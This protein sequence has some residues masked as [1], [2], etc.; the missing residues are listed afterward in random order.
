MNLF[1][2]ICNIRLLFLL[3][4]VQGI[5]GCSD[6]EILSRKEQGEEPTVETQLRAVIEGETP[7]S[8]TS[9]GE[10]ANNV[11]PTLWSE[12]DVIRVYN[13]NGSRSADFTLVEGIGTRNAV[14]RGGMPVNATPGYSAYPASTATF[15]AGTL[16]GASVPETQKYV[17]ASVAPNVMPMAG[18]STNYMDFKYYNLCGILRLNIGG[19]GK[20][21][22]LYLMG[23]NGEILSGKVAIQ[24]SSDGSPAAA[25]PAEAGYTEYHLVKGT[26]GSPAISID[27]GETPIDVSKE[28]TVTVNIAVMPQTFKNGITVYITDAENNGKFVKSSKSI[29]LK[30]GTVLTMKTFD[31]KKPKTLETANCYVVEEGGPYIIP[32]FCRGNKSSSKLDVSRDGF[33]KDRHKVAADY[34]WTDAPDAITNITYLP[35]DFGS[36]VFNVVPQTPKGNTVI[37]LY[38]TETGEIIW[39][40]HIWM[41]KF[42]EIHT[43]GRCSA[44]VEGQGNIVTEGEAANGDMVIMD[45]NLGAVSADPENGVES[46]GLYYQYG[47]KDPFVGASKVGGGGGYEEPSPS[48]K[49]DIKKWNY[50]EKVAFDT[51]AS[52]YTSTTMVNP[53]FA[54]R[55]HKWEYERKMTSAIGSAKF[56]MRF[57]ASN[58]NL[59]LWTNAKQNQGA[60]DPIVVDDNNTDHEILWNR[61][62][63]IY[64]PCPAGWTVIGFDGKNAKFYTDEAVKS[65]EVV[66]GPL[67]YGIWISPKVNGI[68]Q[69][70]QWW[71]SSGFRDIKGRVADLG[72][73]SVSWTC[74]HV[75]HV[76][77][78]HSWTTTRSIDSRNNVTYSSNIDV[79]TPNAGTVRCVRGLQPPPKK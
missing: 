42:N 68:A 13:S 1:K 23:N 5:V 16:V 29:D 67:S 10:L 7:A 28:N 66:N 54:E 53:F 34:L 15:S 72:E 48:D 36:I 22:G 59:Y 8:R 46:Y 49:P 47:R 12:N 58:D 6:D 61:T 2:I 77:G 30:R 52:G 64:D 71:P 50:Y 60:D 69:A 37:A 55:G 26:D 18:V 65:A 73:R 19:N 44:K 31:Y 43:D 70:P 33:T 79:K 24:F 45:R 32:A 57:Y 4:A 11:Y 38:D 27:F 25:L 3:V 41:T 21:K 20:I 9:L 74:D 40:W 35:G 14:F 62:K 76:H 39:S 51:G 78:G 63:T 17:A 75:N 56:P